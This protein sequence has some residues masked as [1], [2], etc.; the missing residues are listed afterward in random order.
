M[1]H[2]VLAISYGPY[3]LAS[4]D[5]KSKN[6]ESLNFLRISIKKSLRRHVFVVREQKSS[7]VRRSIIDWANIDH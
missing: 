5:T 7:N 4:S 1:V 2:L 6:D 3:D